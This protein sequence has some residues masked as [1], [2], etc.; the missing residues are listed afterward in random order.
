MTRFNARRPVAVRARP[1]P[2]IQPI[3]RRLIPSKSRRFRDLDLKDIERFTK[4]RLPGF[5]VVIP[6][7][8]YE[9][10]KA[11]SFVPDHLLAF[12]VS[13]QLCQHIED[14]PKPFRL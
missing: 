6:Q 2:I 11:N 14:L 12:P 8:V 1:L 10:D 3:F 13:E 9:Q 7:R 4:V 5:R